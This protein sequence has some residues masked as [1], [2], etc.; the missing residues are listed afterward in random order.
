M[1]E[2]CPSAETFLSGVARNG[3]HLG[4]TTTRLLHL[5]EQYRAAELE[6][7]LAD[8][9]RR[10]AF[11]VEAVAHILDQRQR[12]KK[13]RAPRPVVLP[14]DPRVRDLVVEPRSLGVYDV[15]VNDGKDFFDD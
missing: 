1:I 5:L 15:F 9:Q 3:G 6:A 8:A 12:S 11:A 4:G 7:A 2:L 14:A 13:I 10:G